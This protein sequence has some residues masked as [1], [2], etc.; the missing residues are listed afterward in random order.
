MTYQPDRWVVIKITNNQEKTHY[1]VFA[2]W[3]GGYLGSNS[4]RLNS[5]IT[6]V[7][8]EKG[9]F[10]FSGSSGSKYKCHP[11][12]YGTSGYGGAVLHDIIERSKEVNDLSTEILPEKTDWLTVDWGNAE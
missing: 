9:T 6:K 12:T 7:T 3:Y 8:K 5:G 4:W 11:K 1:R 10:I 2:S